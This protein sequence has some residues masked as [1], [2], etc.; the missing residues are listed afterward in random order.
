MSSGPPLPVHRPRPGKGAVVTGAHR[1]PK[2]ARLIGFVGSVL[3][4][5]VWFHALRIV[6]FYAYSHVAEVPKMCLG[7]GVRMAPN[8]SI[9]NGE[10]IDIGS[11]AEIGERC[12]L[13]AGDATG[14]ITV[15]D[16]ALFGPEVYVTASNYRLEEPGPVMEQPKVEADVV[17]GADT[18]LGK[19]V[20]VLPGTT[21]GEGCVVGAGSVVSRSLPPWSIAVGSPA[22]VVRERRI[23]EDI[24]D[25]ARTK[26]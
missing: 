9:R 16:R 2:A 23:G 14:R 17:I 18:W 15:G 22:R 10:R 13:W 11:G 4:P 12:S 25:P 3:N 20:I 26:S 24:P 21:I 5:R 19:G 8:V 6:H 7:T 1:M